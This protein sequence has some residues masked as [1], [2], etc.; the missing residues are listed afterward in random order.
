MGN[1]STFYPRNS[2]QQK[3]IVWYVCSIT[4]ARVTAIMS[5]A[6]FTVMTSQQPADIKIL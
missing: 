5:D 1:K 2:L 6:A 3:K 4:F